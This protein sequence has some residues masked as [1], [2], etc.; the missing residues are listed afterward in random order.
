[1]NDRQVTQIGND[2]S[3]CEEGEDRSMPFVVDTFYH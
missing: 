3:D 2:D 1:M